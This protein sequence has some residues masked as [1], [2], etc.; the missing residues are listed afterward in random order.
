MFTKGQMVKKQG[1]GIILMPQMA[2]KQTF[3]NPRRIKWLKNKLSGC[4][5]RLKYTATCPPDDR[6]DL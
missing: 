3:G 2:K 5:F 4:F 1:F 6:R